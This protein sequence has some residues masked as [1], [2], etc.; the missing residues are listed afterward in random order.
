M[1]YQNL[2]YCRFLHIWM[3]L[4]FMNIISFA[5]TLSFYLT[6]IIHFCNLFNCHFTRSKICGIIISDL[7][8]LLCLNYNSFNLYVYDN[9]LMFLF[10]NFLLEIY[11]YLSHDNINILTLHFEKLKQDDSLHKDESYF[12][13]IIRIWGYIFLF[14]S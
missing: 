3:T 7:I 10:Y 1:K 4:Y 2:A 12:S 9:T 14:D 5:P 6:F 11:N 8:I 13:Y